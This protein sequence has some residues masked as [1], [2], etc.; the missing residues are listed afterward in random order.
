MKGG[1]VRRMVCAHASALMIHYSLLTIDYSTEP[2][3][4]GAMSRLAI[5]LLCASLLNQGV[6]A[7]SAQEPMVLARTDHAV[8]TPGPVLPLTEPHL[9]VNPNDPD[10]LVA[11]AI[12][13]PTGTDTPWHCAAFV[14]RDRGM[15]WDRHDFSMER[16]ID[17]W[18]LFTRDAVLFTGIEIRR[19]GE[20]ENRFRMVL[21]R[22]QDGGR[23]WSDAPLSLGRA[24]DHELLIANRS[25]GAV[26][27]TSRRTRRTAEGHLRH[28]VYIAR[29][30]DG[31]HTFTDM[32]EL[33][34]SNAALNPTGLVMLSSGSLVVTFFDFE[35]N[36]DGFRGGGMLAR[37]RAWAVRSD[38]GGATF[39]EPLLISDDCASGVEGSFPGY[40]FLVVDASDGSF[41]DRLYHACV[42]PRFDG[43]ALSYSSDGGETW[44]TPIRVDS[45]PGGGPTHTRTPMLAV[46]RDGVVGVGW[47]DRRHHPARECQDVYFTVSLDGGV[48]AVEPLRISTETS[49]PNAPGNGRAG[50]SWPAGGDYSSLAAGPDGAFQL[51]WADSRTGR[52]QLRHATVRVENSNPN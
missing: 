13:A 33:R 25:T 24:H 23:T 17:P 12:V 30:M 43:L 50:R 48:T 52:F 38:D 28:A 27:L 49:C 2:S 11:G 3:T 31:G 51:M 44:S 36:V 10:H 42:R 9:A 16:C 46:N 6:A 15:S 39:T 19:D 22:S 45:Q 5:C 47:Y 8:N 14:S 7:V 18:V 40:P 34:P 20:D 26:Y 32:A 37:A 41:R 29:S 4:S 35:R 1:C 21:F